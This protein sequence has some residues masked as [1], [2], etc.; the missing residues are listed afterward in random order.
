V[1]FVSE[2]QIDFQMPY[3]TPAGDATVRVDRDGQMGNTVT[4]K[5]VPAAP[6]LLVFSYPGLEGYA[7][8]Y[9]N[10]STVFAVPVTSGISSNPAH[11]GDT[12]VFF[13][14]GLG[15]TNPPA[16]DGAAPAASPIP[17][18]SHMIIGQS[19]LPTSGV[20]VVPSYAGLTPGSIG[21]YQINVQLPSNVTK[22][23]AVSA[24]LDMGGGVFSNR[25]L[26]AI[27]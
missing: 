1:Y 17:G 7:E 23:D 2:T 19:S 27:Q 11:A 5:V 15:Q 8:A 3:A 14:F 6:R 9:I 12:V 24:M 22:G 10:S 4:V 13:A 20:T 16:T 26:I 18:T 21:V 25:V